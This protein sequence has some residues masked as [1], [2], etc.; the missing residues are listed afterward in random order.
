MASLALPIAAA[1]IATAPLVRMLARSTPPLRPVSPS[2]RPPARVRVT[3]PLPASIRP[4]CSSPPWLVVIATALSVR[5]RLPSP[6]RT[7]ALPATRLMAW[8]GTTGL[9]LLSPRDRRVTAGAMSIPS[10]LPVAMVMP[11]TLS[12]SPKICTWSKLSG[13]VIVRPLRLSSPVVLRP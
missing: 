12:T 2:L 9:R 4:S 6:M 10:P 11:L 13:L 1:V 5:S 8:G 3:A 7:P